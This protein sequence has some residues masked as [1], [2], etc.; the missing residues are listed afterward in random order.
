[1]TVEKMQEAA[2][3]ALAIKALEGDG[4]FGWAPYTPSVQMRVEPFF[5]FFPEAEIGPR[6]GGFPWEASAEFAGV[7]FFTI[8]TQEEYDALGRD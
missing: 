5:D 1:M 7:T 4:F 2:K 3:A 6:K 8:L